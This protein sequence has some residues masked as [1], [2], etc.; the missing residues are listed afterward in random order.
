MIGVLSFLITI[1][2]VH[3]QYFVIA[4][5]YIWDMTTTTAKEENSVKQWN[6][7]DDDDYEDIDTSEDEY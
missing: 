1:A 2:I 5:I 6:L 7:S 3:P 4:F